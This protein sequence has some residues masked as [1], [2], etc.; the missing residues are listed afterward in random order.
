VA[1]ETA[2]REAGLMHQVGDS[3]AV[4]ASLTEQLGGD[5]QNAFAI[6]RGLFPTDFHV[7]YLRVKIA[8]DFLHDGYHYYH[9]FMMTI[10]INHPAD[11]GKL[12]WSTRDWFCQKYNAVSQR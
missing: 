3:D 12:N 5:F 10:M 7:F 4:E 9:C 6:L 1:V 11:H 2:V 8:L